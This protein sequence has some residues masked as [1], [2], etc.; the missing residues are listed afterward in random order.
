[1]LHFV[2]LLS[3]IFLA[4]VNSQIPCDDEY[5][6]FCPD[7]AGLDV[8]VCLKESG[9]TLSESCK[10]YISL[11]ETCSEDIECVLHMPYRMC[12]CVANYFQSRA[13]C[14]GKEYTGD[15]IV[16]LSEWTKPDQL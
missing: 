12:F 7:K 9:Q 5:G 3:L 13:N 1:M 6:Q 4:I 16:C 11:H 8:G 2:V 15:L 14:K 10:S